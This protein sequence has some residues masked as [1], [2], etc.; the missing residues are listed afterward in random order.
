MDDKSQGKMTL[1]SEQIRVT[2]STN[3]IPDLLREALPYLETALNGMEG[4]DPRY[5]DPIEV[6]PHL[7]RDLV[8]VLIAETKRAKALGFS[9]EGEEQSDP[10]DGDLNPFKKLDFEFD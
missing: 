7:F 3:S 1:S 2:D 6:P 5:C 4:C 9:L 10:G 8:T